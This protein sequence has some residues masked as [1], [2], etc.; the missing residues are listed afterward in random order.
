[1]VLDALTHLSNTVIEELS[2]SKEALQIAHK[3][4]EEQANRDYL[5][6]LYN[7]RFFNNIA[8]DF[9]N[10]AKRGNNPFSVI[11]L[12]IDRFKQI[13]D[14]Y[15]H[16]TGDE[17][18]KLLALLL[19]KH[20]R[21]SDIVSRFGGDE[22]ALLL[23]HTDKNGALKIAEQLRTIVENKSLQIDEDTIQFTISLGV[24]CVNNDIDSDISH[25]LNRA[26]KSLY[27]AKNNGRNMVV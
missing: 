15:G 5:T 9:L 6:N 13:N 22:F 27:I 18:I 25:A 3:K 8:Q 21:N 16:S 24:G 11:M 12:D 7:R 19:N 20:T 26:D 2:N 17:I 10:S 4:L 1:M 23:P 14:K